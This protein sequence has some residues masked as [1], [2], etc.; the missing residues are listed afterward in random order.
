MDAKKVGIAGVSRYG[1][2]ALAFE[3]SF[4]VALVGSS[5]EAV[6]SLTGSGEYHWMAGNFLKYGTAE[7][8]FGS[9]HAGDIPVDAPH[10]HQLR[11]P[12]AWRCELARPAGQLHGHRRRRTRLPPA[13]R[14]GHR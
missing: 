1:K 3:P 2:A 4:A 11:H 9:K 5:G 10:L 12:G 6:E 14:K 8:K 7:S 13:R